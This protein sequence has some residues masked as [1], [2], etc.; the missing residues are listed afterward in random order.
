MLSLLAG[1]LVARTYLDIWFTGFNGVVVRSIVSKDWNLFLKNAIILFGF[2]MWPMVPREL[3]GST[4][5][6]F[7]IELHEQLPEAGDQQAVTGLPLQ[8]DAPRA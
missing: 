8:A 7:L 5:S 2:M 4:S 6:K 3:V 1:I